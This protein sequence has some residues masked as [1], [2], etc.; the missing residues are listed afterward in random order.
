MGNECFG[1]ASHVPVV[2]VD[3]DIHFKRVVDLRNETFRKHK[4]SMLSRPD[5]LPF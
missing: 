3:N 5:P 2:M 4:S 1:S